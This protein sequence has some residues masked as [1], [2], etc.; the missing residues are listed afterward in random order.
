MR[1][2]P[3]QKLGGRPYALAEFIKRPQ[4]VQISA[5][6]IC[7]LSTQKSMR[8]TISICS[9]ALAAPSLNF[10]KS[11][12]IKRANAHQPAKPSGKVVS[13]FGRCGWSSNERT[14]P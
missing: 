12:C 7:L 11:R 4:S 6:S 2:P 1:K 13:H 3:Q 14:E 10:Y 9:T 5:A 8:E